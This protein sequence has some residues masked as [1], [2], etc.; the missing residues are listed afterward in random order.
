MIG[1]TPMTLAY[2]GKKSCHTTLSFL[3]TFIRLLVGRKGYYNFMHMHAPKWLVEWPFFNSQN[4]GK[5][6]CSLISPIRVLD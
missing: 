6:E 2:M 5:I 1:G 3:K 4:N